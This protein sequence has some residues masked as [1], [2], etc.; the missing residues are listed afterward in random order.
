MIPIGSV[1]ADAS[2]V[3]ASGFGPELGFTDKAAFGAGAGT[4]LNTATIA[5]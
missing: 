5:P 3:T 2:A 1:D 4:V